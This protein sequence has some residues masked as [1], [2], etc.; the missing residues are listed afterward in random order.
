MFGFNLAQW[1]DDL[2]TKW[3]LLTAFG[4]VSMII[5]VMSALGV[6][7]TERLRQQAEA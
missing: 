3:K 2:N 1:F 5:I 6:W 4:M 7:T